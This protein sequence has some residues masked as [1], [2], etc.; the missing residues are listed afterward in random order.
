MAGFTRANISTLR[1]W[2]LGRPRLHNANRPYPPVIKAADRQRQDM[3][4]FINLIEVHVLVALRRIHSISLSKIR[5]AVEWLH[6]ETR[7]DH[8]LAELKIETDGFNLFIRY[9][10]ELVSASEQGQIVIRDIV[11][12][13]MRRVGRDV[14]G[15][16]ELF[17]PFTYAEI[18]KECP[19]E[20]VINPAV[21]F[22]RPVMR[23]TRVSTE[24]VFERYTAGES[25]TNIAALRSGA[26]TR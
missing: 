6:K 17:F 16:P 24:I 26:E 3:L 19:M 9:L 13:F 15:L 1:T 14:H 2:V 12:R 20:V 10:G 21:A 25:V 5:K 11:E 22:G 8:P 4:S 7:F 18:G 23:G